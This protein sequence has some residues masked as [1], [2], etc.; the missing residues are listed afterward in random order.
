[1]KYP[2]LWE[3]IPVLPKP[4]LSLSLFTREQTNCFFGFKMG[5]DKLSRTFLF[6]YFLQFKNKLVIV[7]LLNDLLAGAQILIK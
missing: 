4:I 5:E 2:E 3:I 6:F 7:Q 1:M